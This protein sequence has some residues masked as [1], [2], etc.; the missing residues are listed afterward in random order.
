LNIAQGSAFPLNTST[1]RPTLAGIAHVSVPL[2]YGTLDGV[3]FV[4][5]LRGSDRNL[6]DL[7]F[8]NWKPKFMENGNI[9]KR[10]VQD[11]TYKLYD[12]T[13]QNYFF[14]ISTDPFELNPIPNDQLTDEEQTIKHKFR[15]VLRSMH[16]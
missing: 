12:S 7:S 13:N 4:P 8:C 5:A 3:S 9:F 10:W 16:N 6:R 1:I 14:N 15:R 2:N 11:T